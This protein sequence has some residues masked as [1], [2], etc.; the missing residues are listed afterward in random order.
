MNVRQVVECLGGSL[1]VDAGT[2]D[3]PVRCYVTSDLMSEV[4]LSQDEDLV[5]LTGLNSE[6]VVR[7][8]HVLGACAVILL[9]G[10]APAPRVLETGRELGVNIGVTPY[11][12]ERAIEILDRRLGDGNR[13]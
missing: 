1:R 10:R 6:H 2:A 8:A 13:A 3:Q 12:R 5:I 7:T 11:N 9:E 4:L